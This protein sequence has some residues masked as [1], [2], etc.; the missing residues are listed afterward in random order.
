MPGA[1]NTCFKADSVTTMVLILMW[2]ANYLLG[3]TG[4]LS[5][6]PALAS[7]ISETLRDRLVA[8]RKDW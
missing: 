1:A 8:I 2:C 3:G 6:I 7:K 5:G 4:R